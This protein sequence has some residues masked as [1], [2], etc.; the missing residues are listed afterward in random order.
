M[1]PR[2]RVSRRA[3]LPLAAE[4]H[5]DD[6][7]DPRE[8][9]RRDT[10]RKGQRKVRQLCAQVA[11]TLNLVIS[12]EF[13]DSV[14]QS[15]QVVAVDPAPDASQLVV[16]VNAGLPGEVANPV[17]VLSRLEAVAGKLRAEV[18]TAITRKKAPKLLF[19]VG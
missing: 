12:G 11:D 18:A 5:E 17:E 14:L 16:T 15:L 7:I 2:K 19:R 9:A 6:G 4:I 1:K 10:P 13:G 8:L 3:M